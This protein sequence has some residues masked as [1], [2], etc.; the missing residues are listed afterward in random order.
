MDGFSPR[1]E[2]YYNSGLLVYPNFFRPNFAIDEEMLRRDRV[3]F[4]FYVWFEHVDE[5][6]A[7]RRQLR[8]A[9]IHVRLDATHCD[10]GYN[11]V[12]C[13]ASQI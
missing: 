11:L 7:T 2:A 12:N 5:V 10:A 1:E 3:R 9:L 4:L 8:T 6:L 13:A